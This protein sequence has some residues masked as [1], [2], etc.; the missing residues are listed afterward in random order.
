MPKRIPFTGEA[1]WEKVNPYLSQ[2]LTPENGGIQLWTNATQPSGLVS[3]DEGRTGWNLDAGCLQRWNGSSWINLVPS[4]TTLS[5]I[6]IQIFNDWNPNPVPSWLSN[7]ILSTIYGWTPAQ[8]PPWLTQALDNL[9]ATLTL[10]DI[11]NLLNTWTPAQNSPI[12]LLINAAMISGGLSEAQA[13]AIINNWSSAVPTWL[14][15]DINSR[16]TELALSQL[17]GSATLPQIQTALNQWYNNALT[18]FINSLLTIGNISGVA[19]FAQIQGALDTWFNLSNTGLKAYIDTGD[20]GAKAYGDQIRATLLARVDSDYNDLL[21]RINT[22][23]HATPAPT[24]TPTPTTAPA[25]FQY[26][27]WPN[28]QDNLYESLNFPSIMGACVIDKINLMRIYVWPHRFHQAVDSVGSGTWGNYSASGKLVVLPSSAWSDKSGVNGSPNNI[29]LSGILAATT[30]VASFNCP[31][32]SLGWSGE[33]GSNFTHKSTD[34]KYF[35]YLIWESASFTGNYPLRDFPMQA[36]LS[37][38]KNTLNDPA[39]VDDNTLYSTETSGPSTGPIF[40]DSGEA[41]TF[42]VQYRPSIPTTTP[43]PTT[44]PP[45]TTL[46]PS[47]WYQGNNN[48]DLSEIGSIA[49]VGTGIVTSSPITISAF[50]DGGTVGQLTNITV[51]RVPGKINGVNNIPNTISFETLIAATGAQYNS[52]SLQVNDIGDATQSE[53]NVQTSTTSSD[54]G[55]NVYMKVNNTTHAPTTLRFRQVITN[56]SAGKIIY[57]NGPVFLG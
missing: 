48:Y 35:V 29:S 4:L 45:T 32:N 7:L 50:I 23:G 34:N 39:G 30:N 3:D 41:H 36:Y 42:V 31:D 33:I 25:P 54:S 22:H 47:G 53:F 18:P 44:P 52:Y 43:P 56:A 55:Y 27:C 51:I 19:T 12:D 49:Y 11:V 9:L 16:L 40:S 20:A 17:A 37:I 57:Y 46:E 24:P 8:T 1:Y 38:Y 5:P 6:I 15:N 21:N 2:L 14:I 28:T 26:F 10:S 13:I